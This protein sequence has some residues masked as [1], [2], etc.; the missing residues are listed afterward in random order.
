MHWIPCSSGCTQKRQQ[1]SEPTARLTSACTSYRPG[2]TPTTPGTSSVSE[3][4][5]F[6]SMRFIC[7]LFSLSLLSDSLSLPA[8]L[9]YRATTDGAAIRLSAPSGSAATPR[10]SKQQQ[11][12]GAR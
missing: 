6:V 9:L 12:S 11:S 4:H 7:F 1:L 5:V 8:V 2:W 10:C 3:V